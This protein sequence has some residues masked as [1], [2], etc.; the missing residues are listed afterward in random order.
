[1]VVIDYATKWVEAKAFRTN[2][3]IVTTR[4]LYEYILTRF[5]CPLTIVIDQGVHFIDDTL[6]HLMEQILLKHVSSI[7]YN[8]QGNGQVESTD[9]VIS[10]L[11]TKL[12]N[13]KKTNWDEHLSTILFSY[14]IA[15]KVATSYT[16]Y[17]LVYDLHPLMPIKYVLLVISGDHKDAK[18]TR[19]LIARITKLKKLKE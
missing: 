19:V 3:V 15:Y 9:K 12:V 5:G 18:S 2:I 11:L 1:L 4:F 6:Q 8:P 17:Q 14:K 10:R 7:T 13:E 16:P